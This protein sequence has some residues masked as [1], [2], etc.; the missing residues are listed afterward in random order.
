MDRAVKRDYES[1]EIVVHWDSA[2]CIHSGKCV[3]GLPAVFNLQAHPW[4]DVT[5][6]HPDGLAAQIDQCPSGAL[7]YT[8][9][10]GSDQSSG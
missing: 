8:R 1:D 10:P 7:S 5:A 3:R 6:V 9:K 4:I 2:K